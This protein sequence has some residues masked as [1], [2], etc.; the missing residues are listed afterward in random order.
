MLIKIPRCAYS[1]VM[2]DRTESVTAIDKVFTIT[3]IFKAEKAIFDSPLYG[4]V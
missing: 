1:L 2:W 3:G 4:R